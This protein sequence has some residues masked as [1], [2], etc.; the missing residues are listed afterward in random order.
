VIYID[1]SVVLAE[2]LVEDRKA[3]PSIW[4]Q[5]LVSSRLLQYETW[6]RLHARRLAKSHGDA[7]REL[8]GHLSFLELAPTVLA[9]AIEPFPVALRT[10]DALHLASLVYLRERYAGVRLATFDE[11]MMHAAKKMGIPTLDV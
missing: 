4:E 11:R 3:T 9:R 8:L 6:T 5:P 10:L 2:L 1:T 7:A